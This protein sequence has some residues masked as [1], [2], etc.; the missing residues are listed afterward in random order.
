MQR[1]TSGCEMGPTGVRKVSNTVV[2]ELQ[3]FVTFRWWLCSGCE[4]ARRGSL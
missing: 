1:E 2:M 3:T 4:L